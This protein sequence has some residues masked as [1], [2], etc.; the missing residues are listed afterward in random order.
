M[1]FSC[2]AS[3]ASAIWRAIAR[4]SAIGSGPRV[5][6][7][8][9]RRSLD[10]LEDQRRHAVGFFQPVDRADVRMVERGEQA[11]FAREAGATLGV[12]A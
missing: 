8:G 1:P 5:E 6:T 7:I 4:A 10:Q 11:R 12:R 3:S 9:E 2:A